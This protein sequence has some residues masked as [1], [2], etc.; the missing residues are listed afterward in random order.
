MTRNFVR[1]PSE[2][3]TPR[4]KILNLERI[5]HIE[6]HASGGSSVYFEADHCVRLGA[7]ETKA[8]WTA[9]ALR[10]IESSG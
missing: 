7:D 6:V 10:M 9:L 3:K 1:L 8:L 2:S 5:S 4:E